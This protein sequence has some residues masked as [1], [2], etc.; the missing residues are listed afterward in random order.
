MSVLNEKFTALSQ[1][2]THGDQCLCVK[3][4]SL[5]FLFL[6]TRKRRLKFSVK[7]I[8]LHW[9]IF[10][11]VVSFTHSLLSFRLANFFQKWRLYS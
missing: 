5:I 9:I 8:G 7:W 2:P 1:G 11:W 4:V 10:S 3:C 6:H